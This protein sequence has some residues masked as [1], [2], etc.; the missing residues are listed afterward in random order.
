MALHGRPPL[1]KIHLRCFDERERAAAPYPPCRAGRCPPAL[2]EPADRL[3]GPSSPCR[4][5]HARP[6]HSGRAGHGLTGLPS[7][8]PMNLRNLGERTHPFCKRWLMSLSRA[9][10]LRGLTH[11]PVAVPTPARQQRPARSCHPAGQRRHGR[12]PP[13]WPPPPR[14]HPPVVAGSGSFPLPGVPPAGGLDLRGQLYDNVV[15]PEA[16]DD[17]RA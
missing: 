17:L 10:A 3:T 5:V 6:S 7:H 4:T 9:P 2:I 13:R 14:P 8:L 15:A 16:S 12:S 1:A 11:A